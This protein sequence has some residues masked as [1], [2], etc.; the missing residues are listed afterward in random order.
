MLRTGCRSRFFFWWIAS[1]FALV[2]A[3]AQTSPDLDRVL[4]QMDVQAKAF[5][6]AEAN[7]VWNQYTKVVDENDT[8]TGKVYYRR[9]GSEVQMAADILEA[10]GH[11]EPRTVLYED[12]KVQMYQPKIDQITV[13]N[14]AKNK[15][16][17]ESF[18]V[19]G[20]GGGGHDMLKAFDVKYLGSEKI[21]DTPTDKL[22]LTP[23]N[24]KVRSLFPHIVLWID[25][26]RGISLQQQLFQP[27]GDYRLAKYS[28]IQLNQK[29]PDSAFKLK[30]TS[31]TQ[32]VSQG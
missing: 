15:A 13:Y 8:Q 31:K 9:Q 17:V 23:K 7:F 10:N 18:L 30:T 14:T 27:S 12:G 24:P 22:D 19:L 11:P 25:P 5:R 16:E 6:S 1:L 4:S 28:D 21:G 32:T 3:S 26:Q 29:V 20:F 2:S